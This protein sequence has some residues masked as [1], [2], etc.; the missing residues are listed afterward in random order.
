MRRLAIALAL[1]FVPV[2]ARADEAMRQGLE[3]LRAEDLRVASIGYALATRGLPICTRTR[4]QA[5]LLLHDLSQYAP[6]FRADAVALFALGQ[7]PAVE[8]VVAG[9]PAALAG[10][11]AGDRLVAIDDAP[12]AAPVTGKKGSYAAMDAL[13]QR[14][15]AAVAAGPVAVTLERAGQPL[16]VRVTGAPG[17]ASDVQ[18]VPEA[19]DNAS[20]D[21]TNAILSSAIVES[22][23]SDDELAFLIGHEM[24]HNILGHTA[25]LKR[26]NVSYGIFSG[27]GGN[28]AKIRATEQEADYWGV[29]LAAQAGF[30]PAAAA[31]FWRRYVEKHGSFLADKTHLNGDTRVRYL[32]LIAEEIARTRA[33][34]APLAPDLARVPALADRARKPAS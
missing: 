4:P 10:I 25:R 5:G 7:G 9:S 13:Q 3:A 29:Y 17:C 12:V 8:A 27:I 28:A 30:D 34:G 31:A 24:S 2:A 32:T 16:R 19:G 15:R 11:R 21:G 6:A 23:R 14:W 20:A 26:E 33:A 22:A 18:V 1:L